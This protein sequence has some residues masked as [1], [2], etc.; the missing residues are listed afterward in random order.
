MKTLAVIVLISI[1]VINI[2]FVVR[3]WIGFHIQ[4]R[5][6]AGVLHIDTREG[7]DSYTLEITTPLEEIEEMDYIRLDVMNHKKNRY[8]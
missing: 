8:G 2:I 7:K 3:G 1:L 6:S 4:D 5:L